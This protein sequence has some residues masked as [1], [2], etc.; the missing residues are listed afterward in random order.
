M[1]LVVLAA[2]AGGLAFAN[3]QQGPRL[4][5]AEANPAAAIE[6]AGQRIVLHANQ[7]IEE[8]D[9]AALRIEPDVGFAVDTE[10][11]TVT[12]QLEETLRYGTEYTIAASVRG[13]FTGAEGELSTSL[14][15]PDPEVYT[16]LRGA[17]PGADATPADEDR[18][19]RRG[20]VAPGGEET[21]LSGHR[22]QEY[23]V[24]G[25]RI[26][27]ITLDAGGSPRLD[28]ASMPAGGSG[29]ADPDGGSEPSGASSGLGADDSAPGA[30]AGFNA[31]PTDEV[32]LTPEGVERVSGLRGEPVTRLLGYV[33]EDLSDTGGRDYRDVLMIDDMNTD[34]STPTEITGH[35]GE[36]LAVREWRFVPG[37]AEVI[38][39]SRDGGVYLADALTAPAAEPLA[40][41]DPRRAVLEEPEAATRAR[42][43]F[44]PASDDSTVGSY[45]LSPNGEYLAIEVISAEGRPDG[46]PLRPGFTSTGVSFVR[47]A[48]GEVVRRANGM[49]PDWCTG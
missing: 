48:D 16:L 40:A 37:T 20:L 19:V 10:G 2:L 13:A 25:E 44:R 49:L 41:D 6:R 32:R 17:E 23:A 27:A 8:V 22:I 1:T 7:P 30:G 26:A 31:A 39:L 28:V 33:V 24:V 43:R 18:I 36:P 21:V 29:G 9:P 45:C 35:G 11:A 14:A 47:V 38:V 5:A 34:M 42:E 3:A 12:I 46:Y 15:T 4:T